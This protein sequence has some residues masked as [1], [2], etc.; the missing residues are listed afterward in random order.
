MAKFKTK[1]TDRYG[2]IAG[3]FPMFKVISLPLQSKG[4]AKQSLPQYKKRFK[5]AYLIKIF[6]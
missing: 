3:E 1:K 4:E 6:D 5:Q 2:I